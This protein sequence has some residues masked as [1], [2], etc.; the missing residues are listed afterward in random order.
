MAQLSTALIITRDALL[1]ALIRQLLLEMGLASRTAGTTTE[2]IS[3]GIKQIPNLIVVDLY[4]E[5]GR[6]NLDAI[7]ELRLT[8]GRR[9][10]AVVITNHR[11][12][13]LVQNDPP[14]LRDCSYIVRSDVKSASVIRRAIERAQRGST[15]L[16]HNDAADVPILTR[17]QAATLRLMASGLSNARIAQAQ[18]KSNRAVELTIARVYAALGLENNSDFNPRVAA[19]LLYHQ[20]KVTVR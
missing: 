14:S 9:I 5:S 10:P 8:L 4:P 2:A 1:G 17:N 7:A 13:Y 11:S 19:A 15:P 16:T 18:G 6:T 12:P 3:E 20:S